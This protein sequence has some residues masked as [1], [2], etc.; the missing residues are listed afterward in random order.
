MPL[1]AGTRVGAYEVLGPLGAGGMGEVYRARD[2]KLE[3]QVAL[4]ILPEAFAADPDRLAR[5]EREAKTLASLNHPHI[6]HIYGVEE[7]GSTRALV[8]ELVDGETLAE[9][10]AR[11]SIPIAEAL[12]IARQIA[13][14]LEAAHG[15][16]VIHR[17]LKPANIKLR[18]DGV[19]KVLDFGLAKVSTGEPAIANESPTQTATHAGTIL[20]TAA[21]MSPEQAR[22]HPVDKRADIWAFGCVLYEMLTGRRAFTG[23]TLSDTMVAILEREPDWRA[24]PGVTP[25]HIHR[26]LRRCLDKDL[27]RRLRDIGDAAIELTVDDGV[28]RGDPGPKGPRRLGLR[29][30]WAVMAGLGLIGAVVTGIWMW[31]RGAPLSAP[32][33]TAV[34]LTTYPG[35]E[36]HP[37]LS[38]DGNQVA[39]TWNGERQDNLDIYVKLVG[40][41]KPLQLTSDP[42]DDTSPAWSPDGRW[43]AFLRALPGARAALILVPALGGP[44]RRLGEITASPFIAGPDFGYALAWS[45]D[46][47]SV[48]V[49]D[50]PSATE[51]SGLFAWS[52]ATG[53]RRRLTTLPPKDSLDFGPALS[54]DGRTLAFT[55]FVGFGISDIYVLPLGDQLQPMGDAKRITYDNRFTTS[56]VWMP[57]GRDIV[58]TSGSFTSGVAGLFVV[59]STGRAGRDTASRP[60]GVAEHGGLVSI[61]HLRGGRARMV[62]VQSYFDTGIWRIALTRG[63]SKSTASPPERVP[64]VLSTRP[65]YQPQYSPD[66][67]NVAFVSASS[68]I[69]EIWTCDKD[70]ANL[71]QL[72]T[73]AW[74]ET[75]APRWSPDGS[76]I[77]FHARPEGAFGI[78]TIPAGGGPPKRITDDQFDDW[79]ATWSTDGQWIYFTSNRS[80]RAEIWKAPAD[81][82]MAVQVTK[83][84]G[85]GPTAS[86][87]GRYV[88]FARGSELWRLPLNGGDESRVLAGLSDWSRY[89]P[90]ADG[91]YFISGALPPMKASNKYTIEFFSFANGQTHTI[92]QYDKPPFLGMTVSPDGRWLLYSQIDQ[93]GTD[94]MLVE[95]LR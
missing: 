35:F 23:D 40:P 95:N 19:V 21:Y 67:R 17:D 15:T 83:N 26:L 54:P 4:K 70:G 34:P 52:I 24:L 86:P 46:S 58:F 50:K 68:G 66:G 27:K 74:P 87:D 57:D 44:E 90:T 1:A 64:F 77:A 81:G 80:G 38:P 73:A 11:G 85:F 59:D 55:R 47:G 39:F 88:Y 30:W 93:S 29:A 20:G 65:E 61:A 36:S 13:D 79:G 41:G 3:R 5:F 78:Y 25:P 28:E 7:S 31:P 37:S 16:G 75:A 48:I 12:A 53:E 91:V 92:A 56:P 43:I 33:L 18:R 72:T 22:G 69:S 60:F 45:R 62:Y 32:A 2:G 42:A 14:A 51:A 49:T 94:L 10:I 63:E 6:A 76:K 82:G 89:V 8:M 9:R 84:V 71:A